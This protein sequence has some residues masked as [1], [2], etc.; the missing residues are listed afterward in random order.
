MSQLLE[1]V[2]DAIFRIDSNNDIKF[3]SNNG[4]RWLGGNVPNIPSSFIDLIYEDDIEIFEDAILGSPD[5]FSC[6]VRI[7]KDDKE[8]WVSLKCYLLP[9]VKQFMVCL[10]DIS[11]WKNQDAFLRHAAE[12]DSLTQLPNRVLLQRT[13]EKHIAS[14]ILSFSI[15]LLDLDGFKKINDTHGH[16]AG[17]A[18]LI[19]TAKRL[20]KAGGDDS[21]AVRL[22]GD[23]FVIVINDL[24][25]NYRDENKTN[26]ILKR[27]LQAIARPYDYGDFEFYIG[28]SI[29][30]AT[31]PDHGENYTALLKNADTA[32]YKSKTTGKNKI[33]MFVPQVEDTDFTINT[34]LHRAIHEGEFHLE[35]QPL[36]DINSEFFG[37]EALMRWNSSLFGK[38]PPD[39]FIPIAEDSGLMPFLG[40]WAIRCACWQLNEFQ[41]IMPDFVMSINISPVQ[42]RDN[43]LDETILE[44][45]EETGVNPSNLIF[46]ITESTLMKNRKQVEE[47]LNRLVAK[48]IRFAIDDFG[49]GFSSLSYLKYL[50]VSHI[51]IDRSF[52]PTVATEVDRK[53]VHGVIN[54]AHDMNLSCIAEGIETREQL[55]FLKECKCDIIQGFLLGK[56]MA[57]DDMNHLLLG[58]SVIT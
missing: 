8:V 36:H 12:H 2:V 1:M 15:A 39:R 55:L 14:G 22:G 57:A 28:A 6:E 51:K 5:T 46:E 23:E 45:I 34:A 27:T 50:P 30:V 53:L 17:D 13:V 25:D 52:M 33:T 9:A 43:A 26:L 54:L 3:I 19:E 49:T 44:A 41:R 31:Y 7:N 24:R 11:K 35:Y 40:K 58:L 20:I 16:L 37:A 32:M 18:V 42:F 21:M 38:V 47:I 48:G 4:I 10:M 29:G 56:P